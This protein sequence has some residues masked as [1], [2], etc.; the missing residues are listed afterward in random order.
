MKFEGD[1]NF[2]IIALSIYGHSH[3]NEDRSLEKR[4]ER[5]PSGIL[6][7]DSTVLLLK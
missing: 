5:I 7:D 4:Y 2:Q 1:T 3:G 6:N